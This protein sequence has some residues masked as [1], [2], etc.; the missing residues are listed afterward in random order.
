MPNLQKGFSTLEM[1]S[2]TVVA[3]LVSSGV[4]LSLQDLES[5]S[6][7]EAAELHARHIT[8]AATQNYVIRANNLVGKSVPIETCEDVEN[9][10][11]DSFPKALTVSGTPSSDRIL[12]CEVVLTQG[13]SEFKAIAK[14]R[15]T[16]RD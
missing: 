4:A 14:V 11:M 2:A 6:L 1:L 12:D 10:Y 7:Q 16:L 15:T 9:L 13:K 5:S 3:G 8:Q